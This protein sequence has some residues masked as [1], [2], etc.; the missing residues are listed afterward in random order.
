MHVQVQ[1]LFPAEDY[2]TAYLEIY[3][4]KHLRGIWPQHTTPTAYPNS[5]YCSARQ[6]AATTPSYR[7]AHT[8]RFTEQMLLFPG[9]AIKQVSRFIGQHLLVCVGGVVSALYSYTEKGEK[10]ERGERRR[11]REEKQGRGEKKEGMEDRRD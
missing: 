3:F 2:L 8:D 6:G 1:A 7:Q 9:S 5:V 10:R 11:V 4:S